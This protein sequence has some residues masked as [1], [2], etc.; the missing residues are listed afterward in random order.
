MV[1]GI[2]KLKNKIERVSFLF[3]WLRFF[4]P[5][6]KGIPFLFSLYLFVPQKVLRINGS[7]PWPVHFTSRI[8]FHKNIQVGNNSAP[9]M[10]ANGYVQAR[11][12][13]RIGSNF[14][15]GPGVGLI[16]ANHKEDDYDVHL[17]SS[18][19]VIGDNVWIGMNA[20]VLAGITIG[21][22]VVIG[23]NSVVTKNIPSNVVAAGNPCQ[24][25][26]E[27]KSYGGIDYTKL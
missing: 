13:I 5:K 2:D 11:N 7:V 26:R 27:K 19:I 20:V 24:V 14:R 18:P 17:E 1:T 6:S 15:M 9:G 4:Y 10:T 25:I 21:S 23:A 3:F 12:G 16:S 8:L 22:N